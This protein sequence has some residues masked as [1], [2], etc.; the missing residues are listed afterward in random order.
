M[1]DCVIDRIFGIDFMRPKSIAGVDISQ[2]A[3]VTNNAPEV[4]EPQGSFWKIVL[5]P[6]V[7]VAGLGSLQ[8]DLDK[9]LYLQEG[10]F[11]VMGGSLLFALSAMLG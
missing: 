8:V 4:L 2:P 10:T 6:T 1:I 11:T 5:W 7:G 3:P 9:L